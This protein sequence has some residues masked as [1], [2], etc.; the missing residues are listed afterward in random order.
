MARD[1]PHAEGM[2]TMTKRRK[3][4]P[5]EQIRRDSYL[6][7]RGLGDVQAARRGRL[8]KRLARRSLTRALFRGWR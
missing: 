5:I 3:R 7:S 4:D 2:E 8:A 1:A 6:L